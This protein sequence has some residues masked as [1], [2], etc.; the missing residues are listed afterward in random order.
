MINGMKK[1]KKELLFILYTVLSDV[2]FIGSCLFRVNRRCVEL[3]LFYLITGVIW[4][5]HEI[6]MVVRTVDD[7]RVINTDE[8]RYKV[9]K[10]VLLSIIMCFIYFQ[11]VHIY[12]LSSKVLG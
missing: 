1:S 9:I 2:M 11:N 12:I 8:S 6:W 7:H 10:R 5:I 4:I 3:D